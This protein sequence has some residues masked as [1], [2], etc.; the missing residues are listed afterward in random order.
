MPK[1]PSIAVAELETASLTSVGAVGVG[2]CVGF[3][4]AQ[5]SVAGNPV[6]GLAKFEVAAAGKRLTVVT[7]GEAV[8]NIGAAVASVG[9]DLASNASG[10]L[11]PAVAGNQII[12]RAL[13]TGANGDYIRVL[14]C[15]EGAK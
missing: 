14:I 3:D 4:A 8:A 11:I 15:R 2:R 1:N 13:Q 6:Y 10:Q 5:V 9:L 12:A 7:H